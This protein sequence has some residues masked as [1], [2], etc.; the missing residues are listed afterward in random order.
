[1]DVLAAL[2]SRTAACETRAGRPSPANS[3]RMEALVRGNRGAGGHPKG[4]GGQL[5]ERGFLNH[6]DSEPSEPK[7]TRFLKIYF[8]KKPFA[9]KVQKA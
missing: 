1:M 2:V 9:E 7:T 3:G 6:R 8:A 4:F 5:A